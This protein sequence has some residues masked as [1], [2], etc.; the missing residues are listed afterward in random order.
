MIKTKMMKAAEKRLGRN[1]EDIVPET[2][3]KLGS[4][5]A[6]GKA[7]NIN[8]NTLYYWLLRLGYSR[9]ITI[10]KGE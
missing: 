9:K 5:E 8:P 1:L 2:Y 6:A 10:V 7:L 4:L 3:D